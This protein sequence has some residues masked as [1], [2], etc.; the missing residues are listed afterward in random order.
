MLACIYTPRGGGLRAL[1]RRIMHS[2]ALL[3]VDTCRT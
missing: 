2:A 1:L 3:K